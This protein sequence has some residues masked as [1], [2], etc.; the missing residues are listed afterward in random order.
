MFKKASDFQFLGYSDSDW[1]DSSDD[2]RSTSDYCFNLGS[3]MFSW[4]SEK[5]DIVAQ[6]IAEAEYVAAASAVNQA[7]WIRSY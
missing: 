5:Q 3:G 7:L 1:A 4:C 6:S 2:M